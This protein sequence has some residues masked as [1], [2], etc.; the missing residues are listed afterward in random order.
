M[1]Y[2]VPSV[3]QCYDFSCVIG[4]LQAW[5]C[6]HAPLVQSV[7]DECKGTSLSEQVA[8]LFGVVRDVV[9]AQQCVDEN[10]KTLYDFVK[11]FFENLDL[12]EEVNKW[13]NQAYEDGKLMTLFDKYIP[14]ITPEMYG[15]VGDGITDDTLALQNAC[16]TGRNVYLSKQYLVS[17]PIVSKSSLF[18][19]GS[20]F[21]AYNTN[22]GRQGDLDNIFTF[23]NVSNL[24]IKGITLD[25]KRDLS[26]TYGE[27]QFG[28]WGYCIVLR[29]CKNIII[30]GI[31]AK[32]AQ[33][34]NIGV[35]QSQG[36]DSENITIINN[37]LENAYRNDISVTG[38]FNCTI[39][40]NSILKNSGYCG[41]IIEPDKNSNSNTD[42]ISVFNN[43][44]KCIDRAGFTISAYKHGGTNLKHISFKDNYLQKT[45]TTTG[46]AQYSM[47]FGGA[48]EKLDIIDN[49]IFSNTVNNP[50]ALN[51]GI[52]VTE[53][54]KEV[55][56]KGNIF[57]TDYVSGYATFSIYVCGHELFI[58][59]DNVVINQGMYFNDTPNTIIIENNEFK[60][61]SNI[62]NVSCGFTLNCQC[63]NFILKNNIFIT[64]SQFIIDKEGDST[65]TE[66]AVNDGEYI[67][68]MLIEN[69]QTIYTGQSDYFNTLFRS[70]MFHIDYIG[71]IQ[72]DFNIQKATRQHRIN[73]GASDLGVNAKITF[74]NDSSELPSNG[75]DKSIAILTNDDTYKIGFYDLANTQWLFIPKSAYTEDVQV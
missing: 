29:G 73:T 61:P 3:N 40:N 31:T 1:G 42:K 67:K 28:E 38:C 16:N 4:Q 53:W 30:D 58:F 11:D 2:Q 56:V 18:G 52:S 20:V 72:N 64:P 15:A 74:Y 60:Y 7:Y 36:N 44:I 37:H 49:Y 62:S 65:T 13:L 75:S 54:A 21:Y 48:I 24:F 19:S 9:K 41:V 46:N 27:S 33:G 25:M 63:V 17:S 43:T 35:G 57:D 26:K 59:K 23:E 45:G 39:Q 66:N 6:S 69:N 51:L 12:Q 10:F 22:Q 32:N 8:Y 14:Y 71:G 70:K 68:Q 55:I 34:D 47:L 5:C 50:Q